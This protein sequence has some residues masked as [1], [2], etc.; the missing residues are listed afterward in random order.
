MPH[1][2]AR[3]PWHLR[4]RTVP[5]VSS[6]AR[7]VAL[8]A[9]HLHAD[10]SFGP[11]CRLGP[12]FTLEV[13]GRGTFRVGSAVDF[14]RD[15]LCEISG[16]GK[17]EIGDLTVCTY[18]V[19]IQCSTQITIGK[20]VTLAEGVLVVD[21]SHRFKDYERPMQQQGFDFHPITIGDGASI[22]AKSTILADVGERAFVGAGSVVTEPVPPYSLA[23]GAPARVVEYFGPDPS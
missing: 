7:L 6:M 16:D 5:R 20:G 11:H 23:V 9:T 19:K 12:G 15:F 14:R 8:K 10:V 2:L 4:Y 3:A 22:M 13:P 18:G 1:R 17:V 21:G